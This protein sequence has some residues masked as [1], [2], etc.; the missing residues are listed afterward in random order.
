MFDVL[1]RNIAEFD[2]PQKKR[3]RV[4]PFRNRRA[5]IRIRELTEI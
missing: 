3:R 1:K 5:P 2:T 4:Q